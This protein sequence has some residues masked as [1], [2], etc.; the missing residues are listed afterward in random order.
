MKKIFEWIGGFALIAFS[1]YFT[2]RVSLLVAS[3]SDLMIEIKS[4]SKDYKEDAIDAKIN[5]EENTIIPGKYGR[6]VN[7]NESYL[8][9]HEFGV[10]NENYLVYTKIKPSTSIE[11]NKDKFI[12]SGNEYNREVSFIID[13]NPEVI[14]YLKSQNIKFNTIATLKS[15]I[16]NDNYEYINGATELSEFKNINTKLSSSKKLCLK[17]YSD[18]K[19]CLKYK[20]YIIKP[21]LNLNSI[22]IS[23]IKSKI[24]NG[25]IILVSSSSKLEHV[26]L[27][28]NEIYYKDLDIVYLSDLINEEK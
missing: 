21:L 3:K 27:L 26:K 2:D 6:K 7:E 25:S 18:I 8:S 11:E 28:L 10:F 16:Q 17:D 14:K 23:E 12:T 24:T 19:A 4:V 15:D 13:N 20:Y 1:F 9:M 22:N 5:K